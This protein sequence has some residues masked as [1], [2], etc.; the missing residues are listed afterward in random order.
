MQV[1]R[2][3]RVFPDTSAPGR[4]HGLTA[5]KCRL[6][7]VDNVM[8]ERFVKIVPNLYTGRLYRGRGYLLCLCVQ[9]I[10]AS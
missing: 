9:F 7:H 4:A 10:C 3:T 2:T 1:G 6:R 5:E 8:A